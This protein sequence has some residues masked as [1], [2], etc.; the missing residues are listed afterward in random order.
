M[1]VVTQRLCLALLAA[2]LT[3]CGGG[4][5]GAEAPSP[6]PLPQAQNAA[7]RATILASGDARSAS[8]G[9]NVTFGGMVRLDAGTSADDDKDTLTFEWSLMARPTGSTLSLTSSSSQVIEL[10][11]DQLGAYT[12]Q[13]KATDPKGASS[14]Q[15]I[16]VTVDNRAPTAAFVITPTFTPTPSTSATQAVTVGA[17]ILLDGSASTDADGDAVAVAYEITAKPMSSTAQLTI[18]SQNA[19]LVVD[20]L[21]TYKVRAK[22]TD[23][24]GGSFESNYVF[25]AS[26]QAPNPVLVATA[27]A[28]TRDNGSTILN[29]SVGYDVL[30]DAGTST[31]ADGDALQ[32]AWSLKGKP[33]GSSVN[34]TATTGD[35]VRLIPDVLG[36]YA[37]EVTVTDPRGATSIRTVNVRA[38]NRR[39]LANIAT[40]ATP[41]ALASAPDL[42]VPPG[43]ELTMRGDGS[44]D[45]DGD[46][47]S[48]A[49]TLE[50]KPSG[51]TAA[52]S[53]TNVANPHFVADLAGSYGLLLRVT[54]GVGAF[55]ERRVTVNAGRHAPVAVIDKR[56]ITILLGGNV[57]ANAN[58]SYDQDGDALTYE[59]ALDARPTGSAATIGPSNTAQLQFTPDLAGTYAASV[60]VRDGQSSSIA[61]VSVLV[62]ANA[63]ATIDLDFVPDDA[64]YSV[65]LD[66]LVLVSTNPNTLRIVDPFTAAKRNVVLPAGVKS[67]NLSN[68]GRLAV[69]LHEGAVSLIDLAT[70]VL[71]RTSAS[72][73]SQTDAFVTNDGFIYMIGQTGG[74]WVDEPVGVLDGR[75]GTRVAQS[76]ST[77][78]GYFYGTQ[79]G[80]MAE[81]LGKAFLMSQGLSP[82]DISYFTFNRAT[83]QVLQSGD[84]PYHGDYRMATPLFLNQDQTLLFTSAGTYFRTDTLRY[85]GALQGVSYGVLSMSHAAASEEL[86]VLSPVSSGSYGSPVTYSTSYKRFTGALF[87]P[88]ADLSFP[89]IA[90]APSYGLKVFHTG[91]G[92]HVMLLQTGTAIAKDAGVRYHVV[93]R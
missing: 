36:D 89:Q 25:E 79:Y 74:Q 16:V 63:A 21:G 31:D 70:A 64:R 50:T 53:S 51:S 18:T 91:T 19:R 62:L 5:G 38:N 65:G 23:G 13:L 46:T 35:R 2:A 55:S 7:P 93:L 42:M 49:W 58:L 76:G 44:T 30:V 83:N 33:S 85:A 77:G 92:R 87:L 68:D 67:F 75:T 73:G 32:Y 22:G 43:T 84:S 20:Q 17:S 82:S 15:Q 81:R 26:N 34:L 48:Y 28:V 80:V 11:P 40:N 71:L 69:V 4:G 66:K 60:T 52:L 59:W 29:T 10:K 12:F 86:L 8:T 6:A 37:V 9:V 45:A 41:Q 90:G 57:T 1:K 61:Y 72:S 27:S 47:L 56:Q 24:R 88:D 78:F 54:D 14:T 3:A 39:P